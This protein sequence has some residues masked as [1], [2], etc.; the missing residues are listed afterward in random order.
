MTE[1]HSESTS[2]RPASPSP[3]SLR[4]ILRDLG[5]TQAVNALVGFLFAA[6]GPVAIILSAGAQGNL[7]QAELAS[8]IFGCFFVNGLLTIVLSAW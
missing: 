6:T 1:P 8:W 4:D 7:S 5:P 3:A 2:A